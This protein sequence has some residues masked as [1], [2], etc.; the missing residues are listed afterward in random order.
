MSFAVNIVKDLSQEMLPPLVVLPPVLK[1]GVSVVHF[2]HGCW[3]WV[4]WGKKYSDPDNVFLIAADKGFAYL[5]GQN[6]IA[7]IGAQCLLVLACISDLVTGY[8]KLFRSYQK[9][10]RAVK[11]HFPGF[12]EKPWKKS[13][14]STWIS[15]S[16][17]HGFPTGLGR[18]AFYLN[19]VAGRVFKL[20]QAVF[21]VSMLQM[22]AIDSFSLRAAKRQEAVGEVFSNWV[23]VVSQFADNSALLSDKLKKKKVLVQKIV[24]HIG[25]GLKADDLISAVDYIAQKADGA[26]EKIKEINTPLAKT[27]CNVGKDVLF[28]LALTAGHEDKLPAFLIPNLIEKKKVPENPR[29]YGRYAPKHLVTRLDKLFK[30]PSAKVK[31][32]NQAAEDSCSISTQ[33]VGS[34]WKLYVNNINSSQVA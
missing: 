13:L 19:R 34:F 8:I 17:S 6:Q 23:K 21:N 28:N 2:M 10:Q 32:L 31:N 1:S 15:P 29:A 30:N 18:T 33:K 11:G 20:L 5:A 9:L 24:S 7:Q 25:A 16:L 27:I 4:R 12:E 26:K 14:S 3:R 22:E